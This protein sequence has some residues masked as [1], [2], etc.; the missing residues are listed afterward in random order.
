MLKKKLFYYFSTFPSDI[1]VIIIII[2][3]FIAIELNTPF[4]FRSFNLVKQFRPRIG[5][6]FNSIVLFYLNITII[7][8]VTSNKL[9]FNF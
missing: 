8:S 4:I 3:I 7:H 5:L 1:I 2:I 9:K 6:Q